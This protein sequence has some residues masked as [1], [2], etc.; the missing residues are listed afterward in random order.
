MTGLALLPNEGHQRL[1]LLSDGGANA[2]A[3]G[4]LQVPAG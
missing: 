3:G 2:G 1:V 4:L